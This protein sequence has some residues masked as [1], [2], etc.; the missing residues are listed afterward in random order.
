MPTIVS[1]CEI[2]IEEPYTSP[3]RMWE[4]KLHNGRRVGT[5]HVASGAY[6]L[7]CYSL[8]G[9]LNL[10]HDYADDRTIDPADVDDYNGLTTD[11]LLTLKRAGQRIHEEL[12]RIG[13]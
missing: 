9:L 4:V 6:P 8:E 10:L 12:Q 5:F 13:L 2:P 3:S 11:D 1:I 7:T